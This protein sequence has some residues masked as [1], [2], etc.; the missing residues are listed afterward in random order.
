VITIWKI[1]IPNESMFRS[2]KTNSLQPAVDLAKILTRHARHQGA[3]AV[4]RGDSPPAIDWK[5]R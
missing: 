3:G 1:E 4:R 2:C 5:N